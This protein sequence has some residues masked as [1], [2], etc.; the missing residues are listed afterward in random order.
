MTRRT[1]FLAGTGTGVGKTW[2]TRGLARALLRAGCSVVAVKPVETGCAP[3]P[4]D[5]VALAR[6]CARP[7]VA[8]APG[9]YRARAALAPWAA[10]LEGELA[11]VLEALADATRSLT[12]PFD[13][14]L[15]EGAGGL[16]VPLDARS[17][18][19][20]LAVAIGAELVLVGVDQLGVLS[21]V[22]TTAIAAR[23]R[24]L[25]LRAVVLTRHGPPDASRRSNARILAERLACPVAVFP[26]CADD[27]DELAVAAREALAALDLPGA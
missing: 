18:V 1:L 7:D 23:C 25:S 8:N 14:A 6:A 3:E 20:D 4:A 26:E 17:D 9:L 21:H 5:A 19:A 12:A 11:P 22:L 16:L 10:A 27:D 13:I 24:G 15:V 2:V